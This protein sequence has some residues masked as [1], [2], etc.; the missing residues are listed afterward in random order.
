MKCALTQTHARAEENA[1]IK[2]RVAV[3]FTSIKKKKK[4]K[5]IH[6]HPVTK[7]ALDYSF[8]IT[9][10]SFTGTGKTRF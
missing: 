6:E 3:Y 10:V 7:Q 5:T 4:K 1:Q 9:E 8:V 2:R